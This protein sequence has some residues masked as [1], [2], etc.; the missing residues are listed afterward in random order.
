M[1]GGIG[2]PKNLAWCPLGAMRRQAVVLNVIAE[3][4][5]HAK[6]ILVS[7]CQ[8]RCRYLKWRPSYVYSSTAFD[9]ER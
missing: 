7:E 6:I 9:L 8:S 2:P 1:K 3:V 4:T 5:F